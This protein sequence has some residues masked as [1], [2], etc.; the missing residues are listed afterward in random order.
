MS[1]IIVG[2]GNKKFELYKNLDSNKG[3]LKSKGHSACR[4][5][6]QF[7]PYQF[8]LDERSKDPHTA[9]ADLTRCIV[10]NIPKQVV[11]YMKLK[12]LPPKRP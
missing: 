5:I 6:V 4:D 8:F 12:N 7:V 11:D 10:G 3:L 2:I 9:V 1:I